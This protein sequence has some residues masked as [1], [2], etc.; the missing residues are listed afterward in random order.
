MKPTRGPARGEKMR[1]EKQKKRGGEKA[2]SKSEDCCVTFKP[3]NYLEIL[4]S[5]HAQTLQDN[6]LHLDHKAVKCT[7]CKLLGG[8][9]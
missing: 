7:T 2:K 8:K 6:I 5:A 1:Q 9:F 4:F 3:K